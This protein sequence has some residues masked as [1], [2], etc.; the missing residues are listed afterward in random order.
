MTAYPVMNA[1]KWR[2]IQRQR[3][4]RERAWGIAM[5]MIGVG[6]ILLASQLWLAIQQ[7]RSLSHPTKIEYTLRAIAPHQPHRGGGEA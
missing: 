5:L 4:S 6:C 3:R 7:V 1:K 2:K